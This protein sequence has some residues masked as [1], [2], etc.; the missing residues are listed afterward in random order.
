MIT[1][2]DIIILG[3]NVAH[4]FREDDLHATIGWVTA[5][6]FFLIV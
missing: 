1:L 4:A 6:I 2:L 5:F 3:L